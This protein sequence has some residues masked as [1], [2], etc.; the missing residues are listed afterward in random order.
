MA[1]SQ[2]QVKNKMNRKVTLFLAIVLTRLVFAQRPHTSWP[3]IKPFD[4]MFS[5]SSEKD[6]FLHFPIMDKENKEV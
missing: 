1:R 3:T 6:M 5:F 2:S 4:R